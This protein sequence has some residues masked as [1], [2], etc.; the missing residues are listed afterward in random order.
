MAFEFGNILMNSVYIDLVKIYC[1]CWVVE[2]KYD[3]PLQ[4]VVL[5]RKE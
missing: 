3:I 4:P 5:K 2:L 1:L